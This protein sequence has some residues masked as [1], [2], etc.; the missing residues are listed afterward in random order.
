[1]S[2]ALMLCEPASPASP[3]GALVVLYV[4]LRTSELSSPTSLTL[5]VESPFLRQLTVA[6]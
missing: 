3:L 6:Y 4:L 2:H 5:A 1:M